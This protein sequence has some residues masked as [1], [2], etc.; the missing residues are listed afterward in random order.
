MPHRILRDT[1]QMQYARMR[2]SREAMDV[3]YSNTEAHD[4]AVY[5]FFMDA[6]HLK[7]WVANDPAVPEEKRAKIEGMALAYP[8]LK[9]AQAF[10]NGAKH[11]EL[12]DD[13]PPEH[14]ATA[15]VERELIVAI[16][17][18]NNVRNV[19]RYLVDGTMMTATEIADRVLNDWDNLIARLGLQK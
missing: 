18:P 15:F 5:H 16:A 3:G 7:D 10:A 9:A 8:T 17:R 4:D 2:R 1:W 11:L 13:G 6:W 14:A 19:H 12:R